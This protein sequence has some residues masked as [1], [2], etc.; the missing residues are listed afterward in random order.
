VARMDVLKF[1]KTLVNVPTGLGRFQ[2]PTILA[3]ER[4]AKLDASCRV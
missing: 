1:N 3:L 4:Q 2:R